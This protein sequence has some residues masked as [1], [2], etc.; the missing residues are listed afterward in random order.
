MSEHTYLQEEEMI[1]RAIH[2]L[3]KELGP[4]ETTRFLTLSPRKRLD[5]VIRHRLWQEGLDREQFYDPVLGAGAPQDA[6]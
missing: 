2:V 6:A 5:S 3:V 1:R 4:I